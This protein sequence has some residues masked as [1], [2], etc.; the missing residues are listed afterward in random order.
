MFSAYRDAFGRLSQA[1]VNGLEL[2]GRNM[3]ENVDLA[4]VQWAAY[5]LATV[6]HECANRWMPLTEFGPKDYF[7]Q[8]EAGTAKGKTLV[9]P[10]WE[11]GFGIEGV[12]MY[13]LR[14]GPTMPV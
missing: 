8:Y 12:A 6:K 1:T 13:R 4:S 9:I 10:D 11:M 14:V 7:D 2:L 3:E 5:M